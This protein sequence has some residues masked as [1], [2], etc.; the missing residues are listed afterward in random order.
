MKVSFLNFANTAIN[1]NTKKLAKKQEKINYGISNSIQKNSIQEALG[2]SQVSFK[3]D[4]TTDSYK[5]IYTQKKNLLSTASEQIEYDKL[6]NT[7]KFHQ[8]HS[9]GA[10]KRLY[11]YDPQNNTEI[12]KEFDKDGAGF[13]EKK[14][15]NSNF[16][17][18]YDKGGQPISSKELF[19]D[20]TFET[21][22]YEYN[23][24]R[25]IYRHFNSSSVADNL[26]VYDS[27]TRIE[28]TPDNPKTIAKIKTKLQNGFTHYKTYNL[29]TNF[30]YEEKI[31]NNER[32][33]EGYRKNNSGNLEWEAKTDF[34]NVLH[35][36]FYNNKG[37]VVNDIMYDYNNLCK[38]EKA[39]DDNGYLQSDIL[40]EYDSKNKNYEKTTYYDVVTGDVYKTVAKNGNKTI[41]TEFD[42]NNHPTHEIKTKNNILE[43]ETYFYTNSYRP[44]YVITNIANQRNSNF[45]Y[46]K[47]VYHP[48]GKI[49]RVELMKNNFLD[50][51]EFYDDD[52]N[53]VNK[54]R[55]FNRNSED[56]TDYLYDSTGVMVQKQT[57]E[58]KGRLYYE[59][60]Y[61][62]NTDVISHEVYYA[63]SGEIK[64][65]KYT[66]KNFIDTIEYISADGNTKITEEYYFNKNIIK[67]KRIEDKLK[68]TKEVF[69]FDEY[70]NITYHNVFKR[71]ERTNQT[72]NE[73]RQQTQ[74]TANNTKETKT[75]TSNSIEDITQEI[76]SKIFK[77]N[78]STLDISLD[79]WEI[80]AKFI[81]LNTAHELL[82]I[83][84][85]TYRKVVKNIHPDL[86]QDNE[87]KLYE[88]ITKIV[89][90]M[91]E[92]I[93]K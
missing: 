38:Y 63:P 53:Y 74:S 46:K 23:N 86:K 89:N 77:N 43:S 16:R 51:I 2:R 3:G 19:P 30:I 92:K 33:I 18:E 73:Y 20:G 78:F 52:S 85:A 41:L 64:K 14:S 57:F 81:G 34:D 22:N 42:E 21:Y 13:E 45:D 28:L 80:F 6:T 61:Y 66:S 50:T 82:N 39:F 47:E 49:K 40:I 36:W 44:H 59:A 71:A 35:E 48:N 24:G 70:G 25:I 26:K 10:T 67:E 54:V 88:E 84:K 12:N 60:K 7:F 87:K 8:T 5:I 32:L 62:Y 37:I 90:Y 29:L 68:N 93:N 69:K 58:K 55:V 9:N 17:C 27:T 83:D 75:G 1:N 31:K 65:I 79:D 76:S 91:Y 11:I 72:Y 4:I 56:F 15:P